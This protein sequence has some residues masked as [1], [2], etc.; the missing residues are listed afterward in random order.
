MLMEGREFVSLNTMID[1]FCAILPVS[2]QR[3]RA[4]GRL[5]P[6][7]VVQSAKESIVVCWAENLQ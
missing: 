5:D 1:P 2:L 3:Q 6:R 7:P 4:S